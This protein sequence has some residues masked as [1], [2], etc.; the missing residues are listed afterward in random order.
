MYWQ[1]EDKDQED[2]VVP[3]D[4]V[5]LVFSIECK[6][7][8]VD[9]A[10][11]LFSAIRQV[12]PWFGESAQTGLH[13]IHVA[14]SGNGWE[15]PSGADDLLYLSR[16]TK[17]TLRLPRNRVENARALSGSLLDVA[18]HAMR[19]GSAKEMLLSTNPTLYARYVA[20]PEEQGEE[21]FIADAVRQLRDMGIRFKK[22][23]AGKHTCLHSA[24][25]PV[26]TRSLM[27][28]DLSPED[29][30]RLQEHGLGPHRELGCGVFIPHKSIKKV[31]KE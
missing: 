18:G 8:P 13:T 3:D 25:G 15:R 20:C 23:L 30:V 29:A 11:A 1:E 9:H 26:F 27:I 12:L 28:A 4:V 21:Q 6:A 10:A 17:L 22:V 14:D 7:L 5:D 2:F 16:R 24:D 19:V 31:E